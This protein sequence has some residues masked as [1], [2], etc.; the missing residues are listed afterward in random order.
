APN[1]DDR[2]IIRPVPPEP[3]IK[4]IPKTPDKGPSGVPLEDKLEA[5]LANDKIFFD[6]NALPSD[7]AESDDGEEFHKR[8]GEGEQ[9]LGYVPGKSDGFRGKQIG[10]AAGV[11]D[12]MGTGVGGGGSGRYGGRFGGNKNLRP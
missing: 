3:L 2:I 6:P 4:D 11:Y 8:K 10:Q 1:E 7:H 9:F 5:N 12:T